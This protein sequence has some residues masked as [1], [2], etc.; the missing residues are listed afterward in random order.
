MGVVL[1]VAGMVSTGAWGSIYVYGATK[2]AESQFSG[3]SVNGTNVPLMDKALP[4]KF[5][6]SSVALTMPTSKG[7]KGGGRIPLSGGTEY[8]LWLAPNMYEPSCDSNIYSWKWLVSL[9]FPSTK[10][11]IEL[12]G[13][14]QIGT[15]ANGAFLSYCY[16]SAN[17]KPTP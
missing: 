17:P 5:S 4:I 6:G 11:N 7:A 8:F 10:Y 2:M 14:R 9:Y 12:H 13:A 1:I 15:Y 16:Y 3:V